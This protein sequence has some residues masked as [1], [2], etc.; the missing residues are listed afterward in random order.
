MSHPEVDCGLRK[1][2]EYLPSQL[3]D[4]MSWWEKISWETNSHYCKVPQTRFPA[5]NTMQVAVFQIWQDYRMTLFIPNEIPTN[6]DWAPKKAALTVR[7]IHLD[8]EMMIYLSA[9]PLW[10]IFEYL[11][12][13]STNMY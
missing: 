12:F 4:T 2:S 9:F 5:D 7:S 13:I 3:K 11:L 8:H 6:N 1:M 10:N